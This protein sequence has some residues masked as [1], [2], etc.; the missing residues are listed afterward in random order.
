MYLRKTSKKPKPFIHQNFLVLLLK[1]VLSKASYSHSENS[2]RVLILKGTQED[3]KELHCNMLIVPSSVFLKKNQTFGGEDIY[4]G[5]LQK[6]VE[7]ML[8]EEKYR[9]NIEVLME[10]R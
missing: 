6:I 10:I 4:S 2:L 8:R 5:K 1:V 9:C 3:G 7:I